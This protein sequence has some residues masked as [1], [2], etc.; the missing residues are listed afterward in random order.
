MNE[1]EIQDAI[2]KP[3]Y[4]TDGTKIG[5]VSQAYFDD[6]TGRP[7]WV[8]VSTGLFGGKDNF[9]PVAQADYT[10]GGLKVP[11]DKEMI[12]SAPSIDPQEHLSPDDEEDLYRHYNLE[13]S[14]SPSSFQG[15][16]ARGDRPTAW[17]RDAGDGRDE[18]AGYKAAGYESAERN[19]DKADG[20]MTRSEERLNVSTEQVQAGKARLRKYVVT[21]QENISVPVSHEEVRLE[22]EPITEANASE[23]LDGQEISEDEH[24]VVL[25]KE[26]PVV[27]KET[28]PVERVRMD[29]E[30]VTEDEE[31]SEE[32]RKEQIEAEGDANMPGHRADTRG[33]GR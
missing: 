10:D 13:F 12:T 9:V 3:L 20:A 21:E 2:G 5:K 11:Y 29:I 28:T 33:Q 27:T 8:T 14:Q 26:R 7:E 17:N 6:T 18:P 24:E 31:I 32:V 22:R 25:K 1:H 19:A 4:G 23:A 16:Q 15:E 30:T